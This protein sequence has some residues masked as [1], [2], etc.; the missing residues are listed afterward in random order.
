MLIE[1][2]TLVM[3]KSYHIAQTHLGS[4]YNLKVTSIKDLEALYT[5][6]VARG[7]YNRE[8]LLAI[9]TRI[10][11]M[12]DERIAFRKNGYHGLPPE[13]FVEFVDETVNET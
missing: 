13:K 7:D 11:Q 4:R 3:A 10:G 8:L 12:Q 5:N 6:L 9:E 1:N 2:L